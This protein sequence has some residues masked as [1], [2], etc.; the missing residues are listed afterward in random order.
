MWKVIF[1][2]VVIYE[3][4]ELHLATVFVRG[5]GEECQIMMSVNPDALIPEGVTE[6]VT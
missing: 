2:G 6:S 4:P 3:T 1:N 5:F